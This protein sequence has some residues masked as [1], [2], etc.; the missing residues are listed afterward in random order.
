MK[1]IENSIAEFPADYGDFSV[2]VDDPAFSEPLV[3]PVGPQTGITTKRSPFTGYG[4]IEAT[5]KLAKRLNQCLPLGNHWMYLEGVVNHTDGFCSVLD[6]PICANCSVRLEKY[7][8]GTFCIM[9]SVNLAAFQRTIGAGTCR[10]EMRFI[11]NTCRYTSTNPEGNTLP[12]T[13]GGWT[14]TPDNS[15]QHS[16]D[17]DRT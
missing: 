15:I 17:P 3:I 8:N 2:T 16:F 1:S 11:L 13:R 5:H 14:N 12:W 7:I 10:N 4:E 9:L 6:N